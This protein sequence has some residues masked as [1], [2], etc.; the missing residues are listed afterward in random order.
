MRGR[1]LALT[2]FSTGI[3]IIG[4][5][6]LFGTAALSDEAEQASRV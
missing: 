3:L 1:A 6:I 4:F 5:V 2:L